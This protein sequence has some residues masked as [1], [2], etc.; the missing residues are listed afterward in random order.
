MNTPTIGG[1]EFDE[2]KVDV[3]SRRLRKLD[4]SPVD[5]SARAFDVLLYL[6]EH[7]GEDVSKDRLTTAAW[8]N[9]VVEENNLNQA[10]SLLRRALADSRNEPRYIMTVAGRGYRFVAKVNRYEV[11]DGFV[12]AATTSAI[13]EPASPSVAPTASPASRWLSNKALLVGITILA[14]LGVVLGVAL[15]AVRQPAKPSN[16]KITSIAVLPFRAI[17]RE[18][19]HPALELGMADALIAQVSNVPGVIVRPLSTVAKHAGSDQDPIAIGR[20]LNV[21]AVIEGTLQKEEDQLRVTARLLRVSD[22]QALWSGRF[23]D[24]MSGIFQVQDSIA[25]LV[26]QTLARQLRTQAPQLRSKPPTLNADAYQHYASGI[27]NWQRRDIDG[28]NASIVDFQAAIREDPNYALAWSALASVLGFQSAFEIKPAQSVMPEAKIA[29]QRAI[30]LDSE[31]ADAQAAMGHVLVQYEHKFVEG[32]RYY[33]RAIELNPNLGVVRLWTSINYL[34]LG[35]T[36]DALTQARLAQELEPS[37]LAYSAH[38]GRVLYFSRQY[39]AAANHLQRLIKLVPTFDDAR[40]LLGRT[41]LHQGKIDAALAQFTA[42]NR[43]SPGSFGDMGRAFAMAGQ[44]TDA[45][46]EIEKLRVRAKAGFGMSY[47]IAGIHALLGEFDLACNALTHALQDH[48]QMIGML[49]LDPDFDRMRD[50]R[51]VLDAMSA[52]AAG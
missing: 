20:E 50:Q 22:G 28:S 13:A 37:N 2:F 48:S 49:R 38:V 26:T 18:Q 19:S 42:R 46:A 27:F 51:C 5:I 15:F 4:G 9:T 3:A 39:Q 34:H 47:D 17:V 21:Y 7:P 43:T 52:L 24:K 8:P 41:L 33:Q 23:D 25:N 14:M 30:D 35:R 31:L 16:A 1:Y 10:I 32:A 40:S 36:E 45:H 12:N 44:T 11:A 6:L 29:A